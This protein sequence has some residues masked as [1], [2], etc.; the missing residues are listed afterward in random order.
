MLFRDI[1][2][3]AADWDQIAAA[4][5]SHPNLKELVNFEWT[6]QVLQPRIIEMCLKNKDLGQ[7]GATLLGHLLPRNRSTLKMLDLGSVPQHYHSVYHIPVVIS[8]CTADQS[9][10]VFL[11]EPQYPPASHYLKII[12][13]ASPPIFS[14]LQNVLPEV[15]PNPSI[16]PESV[17]FTP[18]SFSLLDHTRK[19]V[20]FGV[21]SLLRIIS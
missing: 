15:A 3:G 6:T 14:L 19:L 9:H 10:S 16:C 18:H 20:S 5:K 1:Q 4:I 8:V 2:L 7:V 12:L 21:T 17:Y 13:T 11:V